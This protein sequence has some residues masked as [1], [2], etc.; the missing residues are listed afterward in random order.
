MKKYL[1]LMRVKHYVKN[2]LIFLPAMLAL[3]LRNARRV[4]TVAV[5]FA[6]FCLAASIVYIV[7]DILDV[8]ADRAHPLKRGRPLASGAVSLHSAWTL[9]AALGGAGLALWGI[10][11]F[12]PRCILCPAVYLAVNILYS[13][14]L[15]KIPLLD[16]LI[17][18]FDYVLRLWYGAVLA[19]VPV[20]NWMFLTMMSAAFFMGFGKRRNE[21]LKYG[22]SMRE[23]LKGYTEKFLDKAMQIAITSAIVF[24]SLMCADS[25]TEVARAGVNLLWTTP[26][27][28]VI[29]LR[30]LMLVEKEN[31]DGDP[32]SVIMG[33]RA[34]IL[35]CSGYIVAVAAFLYIR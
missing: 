9:A 7:N 3:Q 18:V 5:G 8:E 35:L 31:S 32:V 14:C 17:L 4:W 22:A 6:L 19:G 16:V 12:N 23:S 1:A 28:V 15:K 26:L 33:D 20:S 11:G 24:Y 30:Y 10:A 27:I 34:L 21:F 2:L 29:C 13:V 25:N